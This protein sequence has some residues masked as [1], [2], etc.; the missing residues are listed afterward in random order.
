MIEKDVL[1]DLRVLAKTSGQMVTVESNLAMNL[2]NYRRTFTVTVKG[3]VTPDYH[4]RSAGYQAGYQNLLAKAGLVVVE[5][6]TPF[7]GQMI[8]LATNRIETAVR[9]EIRRIADREL[10]LSDLLAAGFK[11]SKALPA[12]QTIPASVETGTRTV[13]AMPI[14]TV[15][16]TAI[17]G[18]KEAAK[19][20]SDIRDLS[21]EQRRTLLA[22]LIDAAGVVGRTLRPTKAEEATAVAPPATTN[23]G[24]DLVAGL[25]AEAAK[26][27]TRPAKAPAK[28]P[29]VPTTKASAKA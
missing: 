2:W 10:P 6:T 25:K 7:Q 24:A 14:L 20:P 15:L 22:Q 23:T 16:E 21:I 18:L 5:A 3:K 29:N 8:A 26:R 4:G 19:R 13:K 12:D 27:P 9:R 28:R 17:N 11:R 1:A